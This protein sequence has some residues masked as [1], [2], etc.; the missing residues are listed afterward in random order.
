LLPK[1]RAVESKTSPFAAGA[2]P[3]R[4]RSIHWTRP[5]LVAEIEFAG[6]TGG[7]NVRQA[8]FKG[9]RE[10][11]PADEVV[12]ETPVKSTEAKM[13]KPVPKTATRKTGTAR[14]ASGQASGPAAVMGVTISHPDK[15]L[16]PD[17]KPP[18]TKLELAQYYAAIG[19]WM[20]DTQKGRPCSLGRTPRGTG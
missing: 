6:W 14:T 13:V 5:E 18:V 9:L 15:P 17:E 4:E 7:G 3:P 20:I 16:W 11:K 2:S 19:D 12:A 10:D 1:L 8:A